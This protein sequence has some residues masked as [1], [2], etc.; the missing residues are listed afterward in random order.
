MA[1]EITHMV[2]GGRR[3]A[4]RGH[5]A[6][7]AGARR[8]LVGPRVALY[9]QGSQAAK[10]AQQTSHGTN[11]VTGAINEVTGATRQTGEALRAMLGSAEDMMAQM[12]KLNQEVESFLAEVRAA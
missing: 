5:A 7:G 1:H 6:S 8:R 11:A 12:A 10:N 9:E 3:F 4:L 2:L